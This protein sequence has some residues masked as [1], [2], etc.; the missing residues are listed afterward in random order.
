MSTPEEIKRFLEFAYLIWNTNRL[1]NKTSMS[2]KTLIEIFNNDMF[3]DKI[4]YN[5]K[6]EEVEHL[7]VLM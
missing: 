7:L 2:I 6:L 1:N 3:V 5:I 4:S